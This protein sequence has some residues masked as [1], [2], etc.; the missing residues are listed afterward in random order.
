[1]NAGSDVFHRT[2]KTVAIGN[3]QGA[4]SPSRGGFRHQLV[5]V[6]HADD[7]VQWRIAFLDAIE[8]R[9]HH[10]AAGHM[11]RMEGRRQRVGVEQLPVKRAV[12]EFDQLF[13]VFGFAQQERRKA[14][15]QARG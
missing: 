6:A 8:E 2:V 1:M 12:Q 15:E 3:R 10:L 11:A 9:R 4:L 13:P 7:R 5:A 14:F